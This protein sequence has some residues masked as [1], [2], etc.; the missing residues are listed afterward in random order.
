MILIAGATGYIGRLLAER[1]L[2]DGER[3]RC[4]ARTPAKASAL[5][6]RGAEVVEADVLE[7]STLGPA[8][9]G[10]GI[11][12]Y[13]IHSMGRGGDGDFVER[14]LRG[15]RN[16]ATAAREA[17]IERIVYLGGL[18]D[19]EA[20]KHLRSRHQTAL[21]LRESGVPLT[22]FRAAAVIGSGSESFRTV[23]Y[24]VKR[25]PFMLAP[26]WTANETQPVSI[27]D[28]LSYLEEA[29]K[30]EASAGKT[31]QVGGPEVTTY[32]GMMDSVAGAIGI[33]PRRRIKVPVLSPS[34][35]SHWIGLVTPV[36]AGVAR[37][38][39]EGLATDTVVTDSAGMKMF[40]IEPAPIDEAMREAVSGAE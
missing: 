31:V 39:V 20:S 30:V 18:G 35:S 19:G 8:L 4:L 17:G 24:L 23:Y 25:L 9:E 26:R 16:F 11:A 10:A 13:L 14:D 5:A 33:R 27:G 6:R 21:A 1:L 22:Y 40:E 12:Y 28:V 29:R 2:D 36:D 37:P 32:A 34:L 7:P 38:L 3:V 15:A